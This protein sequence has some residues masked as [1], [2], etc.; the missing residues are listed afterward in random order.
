V[1]KAIIFRD[2]LLSSSETFIQ[3]QAEALKTFQPVYAGLR[4]AT[5][6]L[7]ITPDVLMTRA[8]GTVGKAAALAYRLTSFAPSFHRALKAQNASLIHAHFA[9]DGA[10]ALRMRRILEIPLIVSLHGYDIATE[11]SIFAKTIAGRRYLAQRPSLFVQASRFLCI[12]EAIREKAI[13]RGF[14]EEKLTVH[15][16]G[17]D[18][19]M[20]TRKPDTVGVREPRTILFVGRLVEVKGCAYV[21]QAFAELVKTQQD[22]RLVVIG[23]GPLRGELEQLAGQLHVDVIFLGAQPSAMVREWLARARVL[24]VPSVTTPRGEREGFGLAL[25][26]AQAMGTPV[27]SSWSGGIPEAVKHGE[28]GLLAPERDHLTLAAHLER[29]ISDELFWRE[30]SDRGRE[31]V[32][33]NFNLRHQTERLE[34][35]YRQ[36]VADRKS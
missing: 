2:R 31:R 17:I 35:I 36:V 27:V 15:Y 10:A 9:V 4:P 19:D 34:S 26:E 6:S 24:C 16:T 8:V 20:F 23:D 1:N 32:E 14:P 29:F 3:A 7:P 30:C 13:S 21:I 5:P 25:I 33:R 28:T 11:D 18:C 22:S 12:S